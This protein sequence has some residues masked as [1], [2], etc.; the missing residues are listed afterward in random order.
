MFE[1]AE[2]TVLEG[3]SLIHTR[4]YATLT[5]ARATA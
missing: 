3:P 1:E 4:P 5:A 2:F